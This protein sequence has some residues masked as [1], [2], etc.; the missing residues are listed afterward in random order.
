MSRSDIVISMLSSFA[1]RDFKGFEEDSKTLI[2]FEESKKNYILANKM[3]RALEQEPARQEPTLGGFSISP[4]DI[5]PQRRNSDDLN[6]DSLKFELSKYKLNDVTLSKKNEKLVKDLILQ[7]NNASKLKSY[8][9]TPQNRIL[10]YGPPGTGKTMTAYAIAHELGLKI[11]YIRFDSLVSSFLGRTGSNLREIFDT[12]SSHPCVLLIDELDAIGKKRDDTQ[13]LG[14]LKRIVISLLQNLDTLS[15]NSLLI[16]CTNHSHLLDLALWRRFD[17]SIPFANA[18]KEQRY[19]II[20]KRLAERSIILEEH[21]CDFIAELTEQLTPANIVTAI[22]NGV[23]KWVIHSKNKIQLNIVEEILL[24]LDV[25]NI[26]ESKRIEV[27]KKLREQSPSYSF[28]YLGGLLSMP[29]S[30]VHKK[31][32]EQ[33]ENK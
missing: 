26:S 4:L 16:A 10:L 21:W 25:G 33:E 27:A 13:E 18:E 2:E 28:S 32:K 22:D 5:K 3:K 30:T 11:A 19:Q 1:R 9:L 17:C 8:N 29:K 12:A 6:T 23:R 20:K 15:P 14:E 31:L 24:Y 7:W